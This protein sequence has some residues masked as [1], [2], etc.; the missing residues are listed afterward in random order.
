MRV[1][2]CGQYKIQ[3]RWHYPF[4][5]FSID[6]NIERKE[7]VMLISVVMSVKEENIRELENV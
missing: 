5:Q 6:E 3:I 2:N 1:R 4:N 7:A